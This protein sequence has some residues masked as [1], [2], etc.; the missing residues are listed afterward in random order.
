[1]IVL[2]QP[3]Q[4]IDR[5]VDVQANDRAFLPKAKVEGAP[6]AVIACHFNWGGFKRPVYNLLRF[7]RQMDQQGIPVFGVEAVKPGDT[8]IM[9]G[10]PRWK[11]VDVTRKGIVW[12]KEAL[13]NEA[14]KLVPKSIPNIAPID[15]DIA[16]DNPRWVEKSVAALEKTPVIQPF[17]EAVWTDED[18][19]PNLVRY[20]ATHSGID[21][22]WNGHPGFAWAMNR[23]FFED[24]GFYPYSVTG[25]GDTVTATSILGTDFV[26]SVTRKA[27]G[28]KNFENGV[29]HEWRKR[30]REWMGDAV[31]GYIPGAVW[32]EWHGHR[33]DRQYANRH[34]LLENFD[35][36]SDLRIHE[37]GWLEWTDQANPRM[38]VGVLNYFTRRKEDG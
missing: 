5:T 29:Y 4:I 14:A 20:S 7:L 25:A 15:P 28:Q 16:F 9:R 34:A 27:I 38:V 23:S 6:L 22:S 33:K 30:C 13:L 17:R 3:D 37:D 18:G 11:V 35:A 21:R 2:E 12:Q 8:S 1:M 31:P 32:H 10:N 26:F 19:R 36:L 24:V